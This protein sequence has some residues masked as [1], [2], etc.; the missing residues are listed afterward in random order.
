MFDEAIGYKLGAQV[1][2]DD[3]IIYVRRAGCGLGLLDDDARDRYRVMVVGAESAVVI[4][5][6]SNNSKVVEEDGQR[7]LKDKSSVFSKSLYS[8]FS[9]ISSYTDTRKSNE[10]RSCWNRSKLFQASPLLI[11]EDDKRRVFRVS[12]DPRGCLAATADSLGRVLLYDLR[13]EAVVRIWKGL[14]DARLGWMVEE[15]TDKASGSATMATIL[16]IYAPQ[17]GLVSL[18]KMRNGPCQRVVAVGLSFSLST[19]PHLRVSLGSIAG[20]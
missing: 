16:A 6:L 13:T 5:E 20:R 18:Y 10:D 2:V 1:A 14:R 4:Y 15:C 17:L 19:S 12:L 7:S 3:F 8:I 9:A 11:L